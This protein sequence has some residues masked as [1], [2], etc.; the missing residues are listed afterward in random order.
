M[1]RV[2]ESPAGPAYEVNRSELKATSHFDL[3]IIAAVL[4]QDYRISTHVRY[5]L[6]WPP[7]PYIHPSPTTIGLQLSMI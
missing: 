3:R 6:S 4:P 2:Q 7:P 1:S 5:I